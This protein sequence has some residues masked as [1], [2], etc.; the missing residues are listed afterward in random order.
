MRQLS[1]FDIVPDVLPGERTTERSDVGRELTWRE[2]CESIGKVIWYASHGKPSYWTAVRPEKYMPKA[3]IYY[4]DG[5]Q[6]SDRLVCFDGGK[7]R[8]L[9]DEHYIRDHELSYYG[10][11]GFYAQKEE[12]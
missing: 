7:Q 8:L 3:I 5:P 12:E 4:H 10:G 11:M 2:A 1:L 9:I 6:M